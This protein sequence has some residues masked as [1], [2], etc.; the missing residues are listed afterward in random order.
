MTN[1]ATKYRP[2]SWAEVVGQERPIKVLINQL[3]TGE[4][5]HGYLLT[6]SA[7]TGKTTLARIFA[8]ELNGDVI[9]V[10]AA[11]NNGVD[12]VREIRDSCQ[13]KPLTGTH[14]VYII[15][16][17]HMLST[18]AWNALLK[19][20]EEP[21]AHAVFILCTTDPQKIPAT[22]L[23]RVQRFDMKRLTTDQ[24]VGRL[25]EI[26]AQE[27][28]EAD[29]TDNA[30]YLYD[31]E[32]DALE[33]IAKRSNGGMRDAISLFDTCVGYANPLTMEDVKSVLGV[34]SLQMFVDLTY[35]ILEQDAE[36][37][38]EVLRVSHESGCDMRRFIHDYLEF[39]IDM[40]KFNHAGAKFTQFPKSA[41][42]VID[43]LN[44]YCFNR[45]IELLD[46]FDILNTL[47][48]QIKHESNPMP[49]VEGVLMSLCL[50]KSSDKQD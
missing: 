48:T 30:P 11:S 34:P 16:E 6:G 46:W 4:T 41:E 23:S 8:K 49:F 31:V 33:Y 21:P 2:S 27:S 7:G 38:M 29:P 43:S 24:V 32:D 37:V 28:E 39:I 50:R 22:I 9:E 14:K 40:V 13:Y 25:K 42:G 20:L 18:G 17:V 35:A 1:L 45:D 5:K 19:T 47:H 12:N 36:I 10:D 3:L 44:N 15:D 26:I